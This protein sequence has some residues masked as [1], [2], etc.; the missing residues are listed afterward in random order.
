MSLNSQMRNGGENP[1][2]SLLLIF[3]QKTKGVFIILLREKWDMT[4]NIKRGRNRKKKKRLLLIFM[5]KMGKKL[6]R[7]LPYITYPI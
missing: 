3:N 2:R 4:Q 1:I 7:E 6:L 5:R